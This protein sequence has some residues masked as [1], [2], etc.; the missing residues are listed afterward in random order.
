MSFVNG[1]GAELLGRI[2]RSE[3]EVNSLVVL[4][5][6]RTL[7]EHYRE[8]YRAGV[9]QLLYSLS[10][11]FTSIAVG[12][13]CDLGLLALDDSVLPCFPDKR[14]AEV[15]SNLAAMQICHLLSMTAGHDGDI[16]PAV[17]ACTDWAAAFL[18]QPVEHAPGTRYRYST[19]STY[20]L[21]AIVERAAGCNL[22]DFLMP[23]LFEPLG[24]AR[25]VWETCPLGVTAG[26]MGLSLLTTD[27][28]KFGQMLLQGGIYDGRRIV[29]EDYVGLAASEQSDNRAGARRDR[30]DSA[31][32]YGFQ[33][34]RCR[35]GAYR[36]DGSFGQLCLVS[37]RHD[38]VVAANCGFSSMGGLQVLLD[39]IFDW[40]G[41]KG[42]SADKDLRHRSSETDSSG[43]TSCIPLIAPTTGAESGLSGSPPLELPFSPE[44][45]YRLDPNPAGLRAA[46]FRF[47]ESGFELTTDHGDERSCTLPFDFS[48]ALEAEDVFVKDL[49]RHRQK[50][51]TSVEAAG[52]DGRSL[53]LKL[54]YIETP[55]R[56]LYTIRRAECGILWSFAINVSFGFRSYEVLGR[57]ESG[58]RILTGK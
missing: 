7:V 36:G 24:I 56:V 5:A 23:T 45:V 29:S 54:Y 25:P 43:S 13:A 52:E 6:G 15:S 1:N 14:P 47:T 41:E 8:P 50:V 57:E 32:G 42:G 26:G 30:I 19:P 9:P 17:T 34:H 11:S 28:A 22:V 18:A 39:L 53:R 44:T 37:P 16:Y 2:E 58:Y 27:V 21:A 48:R 4:R 12:I 10:K 35:F 40:A 55:Y 31:Q 3:L 38:L 33:F 46:V 49:S 20:M 51:V